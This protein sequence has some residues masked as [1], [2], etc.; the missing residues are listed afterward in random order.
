MSLDKITESGI[1]SISGEVILQE[2]SFLQLD[3]FFMANKDLMHDHTKVENK[4]KHREKVP[5]CDSVLQRNSLV[6]PLKA[7]LKS[8]RKRKE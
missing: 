3:I 1:C 6:P 7:P 8:K 2:A 4:T 5:H